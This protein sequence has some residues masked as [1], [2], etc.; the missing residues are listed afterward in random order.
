LPPSDFTLTIEKASS[1]DAPSARFTG[2]NDVQLM[3]AFGYDPF[4]LTTAKG[5]RPGMFEAMVHHP[6]VQ[7]GTLGGVVEGLK[8][9]FLALT[10]GVTHALGTPA[11]AALE[12]LKVKL[13][14]AIYQETPNR[15]TDVPLLGPVD[16]PALSGT[17]M[18]P[19]PGTRGVLPPGGG[20]LATIG[21]GTV[22]GAV[23]GTVAGAAQPVTEPG[24]PGTANDTYWQQKAEQAETGAVV[25]GGTGALTST[26]GVVGTK[27]VNA[28]RN[29]SPRY[30]QV[31]EAL[32]AATGKDGTVNER[33]FTA[34]LNSTPGAKFAGQEKWEVDGLQKLVAH[35]QQAPARLDRARDALTRISIIAHGPLAPLQAL[36]GPGFT[37]VHLAK[38]LY[39]TPQ[40]RNFLLAASDLQPGSGAMSR[41][42][43]R[44]G[45]ELPRVLATETTQPDAPVPA[46]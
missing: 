27:A 36:V 22:T 20:T 28:A 12:D 13:N 3:Q 40:G 39:S 18:V 4:L 11:D 43:A 10:Q 35:I 26:V 45:S 2:M 8:R 5:Y 30:A 24:T 33:I 9:P 21:K 15:T 19:L 25:G 17:L 46:P 34:V 14:A 6:G 23:A 41:L 1:Q 32:T 7:A 44:I 37:I 16:L 42:V 38:M 29:L 31:E